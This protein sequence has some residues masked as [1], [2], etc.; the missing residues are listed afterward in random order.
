MSGLLDGVLNR[1][2]LIL[3]TAALLAVSGMTAW[4]QMPRQE[5]PTMP[6][7]FGIITCA[8]PGAD[9]ETVERLVTDPIEEALTQVKE[10]KRLVSTSRTDVVVLRILLADAV[11]D[12]AAAWDEVREALNEAGL[13]AARGR[14]RT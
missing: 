3:S 7:R 1:Q 5:D 9:A 13:G 8:Y 14:P 2:R 11:Y 6:D 12:T 4:F 10:V